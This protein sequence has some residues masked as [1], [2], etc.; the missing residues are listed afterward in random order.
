MESLEH[1]T[2]AL[3]PARV[4]A[5]T[6]ALVL[7]LASA[8]GLGQ[9]V[10]IVAAGV[11]PGDRGPEVERGI[12]TVLL[13]EGQLGETGS[14]ILSLETIAANHTGGYA[15]QANWNHPMGPA[16]GFWG[17]PAGE[18]GHWITPAA[19][20]RRAL[21]TGFGLGDAG[22]LCYSQT[23]GIGQTVWLDDDPVVVPGTDCPNLPPFYHWD[24]TSWARIIPR[25]FLQW[26]TGGPCSW[27]WDGTRS[28]RAFFSRP[29]TASAA[30]AGTADPMR[31]TR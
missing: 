23:T 30:P 8:V 1:R 19:V 17:S 6:A 16:W 11:A 12:R 5:A 20:A 29:S 21:D 31:S 14:P 27:S 4:I 9:Q 15:V 26:S 10:A 25:S 22:E 24:V 13:R 2:G 18:A 7:S 28:R 3:P